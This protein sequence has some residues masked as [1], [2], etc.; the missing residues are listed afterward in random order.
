[1]FCLDICLCTMCMPGA[2]RGQKRALDSLELE[3][4]RTVHYHLGAGKLSLGPLEE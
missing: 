4:Q 3:L 2:C 1:M